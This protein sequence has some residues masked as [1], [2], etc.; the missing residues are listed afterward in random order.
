MPLNEGRGSNPG[1]TGIGPPWRGSS[2]PLNEGRGSNP[3]DTRV[4]LTAA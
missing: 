4:R 1:D 3:G 2:R